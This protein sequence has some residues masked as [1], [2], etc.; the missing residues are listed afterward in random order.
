MD[1]LNMSPPPSEA[2]NETLEKNLRALA[3]FSPQTAALIRQTPARADVAF[4]DAD[5]GGVGVSAGG[6]TIASKR[7]PIE[8]GA[9]LA[10]SVDAESNA[11]ACVLG[12]GAG[13]HCRSLS[14]RLGR[15]GL[16]ICFEPDV[17]LLRAVLE[18]VDYS[19]WLERSGGS[20][21]RFVLLTSASDRAPVS[22]AL[23]GLEG[24]IA[25]GAKIVEHPASSARLGDMGGAFSTRFMEVVTSLKSVVATTL[26]QSGVTLRNLLMNADVYTASDGIAPL[27]GCCAGR[28]GVIVSAGPSLTRN[29]HLLGEP[30]VRDRVL[31]V[32]VQTVLKPMLDAG[33]KPHIVCALDHHEISRRF[34]EGLTP[35]DVD[36]ITLVADPKVNPAVIQA[37]PGAIRFVGNEQ[38][39]M[40]V[41]PIASGPK[42]ELKPGATVAHLCYYVARMMGADPA[43]FIGQ[44][45]GFTDGQ[46]YSANAAIH[47]VWA[48]EL[49]AFCSLES[50]EWQRIARFKR[51]LIQREDVF[52]KPIFTDEQL[53]SYLGQFEVDF[54]ESVQRGLRVI[55]ATEGG[56]RKQNAEVLPLAEALERAPGGAPIEVPAPARADLGSAAPAVAARLSEVIGQAE[57][58]AELSRETAA[59]LGQMEASSDQNHINELVRRVHAVRDEVTAII[60][61]WPLVGF[62]DQSGALVR[63]R[64]DRAIEMDDSL[65]E[66][67][68]QR[69]RMAR[70]RENVERIARAAGELGALVETARVAIAEGAERTVRTSEAAEPATVETGGRVEALIVVDAHT[71]G[72]GTPRDLRTPIVDGLNALQM[73]VM[74][75]LRAGSLDG[76]VLLA[77]DPD[78]THALLGSLAGDGRVAIERVDGARLRDRTLGVG[79]ARQYGPASWRGGIA[80]LTCYDES[81]DP[82]IALEIVQRRGMDAALLV[83]A[84][85]ALVDPTIAD[86]VIARWREAP[87]SNRIVF[88]QSPPGF[89]PALIDRASL[90]T[91]A[92]AQADA[93]PV[94]SFGGLVAYLP[95]QP[96]QDPIGTRLCVLIDERVRDAG[97]RA[98]ADSQANVARL[99]EFVTRVGDAW[100]DA[101]AATIARGIAESAADFAPRH[102]EMELCTGRLGGGPWTTWQR[103]SQEPIEREVMTLPLAHSILRQL[104]ESRE[105]AVLTVSGSGDPLLHERALDIVTMAGELGIAGVHLRTDLLRDSVSPEAILESGATVVSLDLIGGTRDTYRALTGLD[106]FDAVLERAVRLVDLAKAR[107]VAGLM[108]PWIVPRITRCDQVVAE[109]PDFFDRWTM[110]AGGVQ[111]DP[112]PTAVPGAR[113]APLPLPRSASNADARDRLR[114]CSDGRCVPT[115]AGGWTPSSS[116]DLRTM[117]LERVWRAARG[118]RRGV[119]GA[120]EVAAA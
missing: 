37:W 60:P 79:R 111:I 87:E 11:V 67:A 38:L 6:R 51:R 116:L 94:A 33:I 72:L 10:A 92:G 80:N 96:Q 63:V 9:R 25:L 73:T 29:L 83:G 59:L 12:F 50:M 14:E 17:G 13:Y 113:V 41:G 93:G 24:L 44:D 46:Y 32:A 107:R 26:S 42:G 104:A 65:D 2:P 18:R 115:T 78:A 108:T 118:L 28:A 120:L 66:I 110:I 31:I 105:D 27:A 36:G 20:C 91:I 89:A 119:G 47:R 49:G 30:G 85:W 114:V 112:L 106:R 39:D 99:V 97:V 71:G 21:A 82:S 101:P 100:I 8:E 77:G 16:V 69:R 45:L 57:R 7:R 64:H 1:L 35:A 53:A 102:V 68:E 54:A 62:L 58:V 90:E 48:G 86:A 81:F 55:D 3:R 56:V 103:G 109:I 15:A 84:D 22:R 95:H 52:G 34:Y 43:I 23:E 19:E 70:D 117:E 61:A 4:H 74:R 75:L 88:T 76:V 98:A 5:D 40:I